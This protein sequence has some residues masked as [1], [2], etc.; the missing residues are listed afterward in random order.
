MDTPYK[1]RIYR[2]YGN[3]YFGLG[4]KFKYTCT[5][6]DV[7]TDNLTDAISLMNRLKNKYPVCYIIIFWGDNV[8]DSYVIEQP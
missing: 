8:I 1:I 6:E 5:Y 3:Q 4:N 2:R 7:Y